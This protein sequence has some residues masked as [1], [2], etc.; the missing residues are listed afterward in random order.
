MSEN[1]DNR[2]VRMQFDNRQF[3]KGVQTTTTSLHKLKESLKLDKAAEGFNKISSAAKTVDLSVLMD[4]AE[5]IK[6]RFSAFGIIGM[7]VLQNITNMAISTGRRLVDALSFNSI[8]DGFAEYETQMGAI[9]TIMANVSDKGYG[10][11]DVTKNLDTLNTY[12]D[13]TIYNFT[14]MTRNIGTFTAA[15]VDLNEAT[16]AIQGIANLAAVSGSTSQQ[17]SVAMYQ[18]SQ[19]LA[20][21][22]VRLQDWNSV[23]NA[24]MGGEV[25]QKALIRTSEHLQ[26]GAKAAIAAKGSFRESL[27]TG[28]MTKEVLTE[29]L[30]MF[31]TAAETQE[32]YE[33][34]VKKFLDKGYSQEEATQMADMARTAGDAATKVKTFTQ[35]ID[36]LKEAL[37]SGWTKSWSYI[38][39]DFGEA[40]E[41]FTAIS[42]ELGSIIDQSSD[43]RN[44]LL[45]SWHDLGGRTSLL[46]G[47][48][49]IYTGIKN[50]I[51][52]MGSAFR[53]VIPPMTAEKLYSLTQA[54][55]NFTKKLIPG[56][57]TLNEF[58]SI[59]KGFISIFSILG[60]AIKVVITLFSQLF[61]IS[62]G[63]SWLWKNFRSLLAS[64]GDFISGVNDRFNVDEAVAG[65]QNWR[66]HVENILNQVKNYF[67]EFFNKLKS[68]WNNSGIPKNVFDGAIK[69]LQFI[70]DN[71]KRLIPAIAELLK[72]GFKTIIQVVGQ[73]FKELKNNIDL[74]DIFNFI[75]VGIFVKLASNFKSLSNKIKDFLDG[76]PFIGTGKDSGGVKDAVAAVNPVQDVVNSVKTLFN[77]LSEATNQLTKSIKIGQLVLIAGAILTIVIAMKKISELDN[78]QILKGLA[79]IATIAIG[80]NKAMSVLNKTLGGNSLKLSKFIGLSLFVLA[81]AEAVLILSKAIRKL[82]DLRVR[83][84]T[85]SLLA[86]VGLMEVLIKSTDRILKSTG[87]ARTVKIVGTLLAFSYAIKILTDSLKFISDIPFDKMSMSVLALEALMF[88]LAGCMKIMSNVKFT[89]RDSIG[90]LAIAG[91][92]KILSKVIKDLSE[93]DYDK[94]KQGFKLLTGIML[95]VIGAMKLMPKN[96][97]SI[98]NGFGS[99]LIG[100]ASLE[101]VHAIKTLSELDW[102]KAK[103]SMIGLSL[104]IGSVSLVLSLM[105]KLTSGHKTI[106]SA[107]AIDLVTLALIPLA[108]ALKQLSSK[109]ADSGKIVGALMVLM[110]A[111]SIMALILGILAHFNPG[112][113][114]LAAIALDLVTLALIPIANAIKDLSSIPFDNASSTLMLLLG[115]ITTLGLISTAMGLFGF[116]PL[117]GALALDFASLSLIPIAYALQKVSS[118]DINKAPQALSILERVIGFLAGWSVILGAFGPLT[119]LGGL[120]LMFISLSLIPIANGIERFSKIKFEDAIHGIEILVLALG[121]IAG[122]SVPLGLLAPLEILADIALAIIAGPLSGIADVLEKFSKIDDQNETGA[123]H[124]AAT[125]AALAVGLGANNLNILGA[126]TVAVVADHIGALA[127][128]VAKWKDVIPNPNLEMGLKSLANGLG[129]LNWDMLGAATVNIVQENVGKLA[130]SVKAWDDVIPNPNL[131]VGLKSLANGL[132]ALNWDILGA[133]TIAISSDN[134][135]TL[136]GSISKWES[137]KF[138][139]TL[140]SSLKTMAEG[141]NEFGWSDFVGTGVIALAIEPFSNLPEA[142]KKW[143][144]ASN[145]LQNIEIKDG[146]QKLAEGLSSF[147]WN[148][149]IAGG[150]MASSVEPLREMASSVAAWKDVS[151]PENIKTNLENLADGVGAFWNKGWGG[152]VLKDITPT[153]AQLS[154]SVR[155]WEGVTVPEGIEGQLESLANGVKKFDDMYTSAEELKM[156]GSAVGDFAW[157]MSTIGANDPTTI[158][159][160]ISTLID[161]I[162]AQPE[163]LVGVADAFNT[164]LQQIPPAIEGNQATI[165]AALVA[166]MGSASATV[167]NEG[168]QFG[169]AG[170][171][172]GQSLATSLATG[173]SNGQSEIT[174][175]INLL[176][177]GMKTTFTSEITV[178]NTE[179][180]DN[181]KNLIG[182]FASGIYANSYM[183]GDAAKSAVQQ[184]ASDA[185]SKREDFYNIGL[186]FSSGLANGIRANKSQVVNAA[187]EVAA[188]AAAASKARLAEKSPSK[189]TTEQGEYFSIGLANGIR[190]FKQTVVLAASDVAGGAINTLDSNMNRLDSRSYSPKIT[191]VISSDG[192]NLLANLSLNRSIKMNAEVNA[193]SKD[194]SMI[195]NS[196][197]ELREDLNKYTTALKDADTSININQTNLSPKALDPSEV[198]RNTKN[199]MSLARL[200]GR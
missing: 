181:G 91:T 58:H 29:T 8:R 128:G 189:I 196:I 47:I 70:Y 161:G 152:D 61:H 66:E 174:T 42:K 53:E 79:T 110:S 160:N 60:K 33:A 55:E 50:I 180:Y 25:F 18:L 191:P 31:A 51:L 1:I 145:V 162:A 111:L 112:G 140:G 22:T 114:I 40:K 142:F 185:D 134:L 158:I 129:A 28:W 11:A 192:A 34:A 127:E 100:L 3:E 193:V 139:E 43:A 45:Q 97:K 108:N 166:M 182:Q 41:M 176:V 156:I 74:N 71:M 37:G 109:D 146:M 172:V 64:I 93:L 171:T 131:E 136:A 75:G 190:N 130:S 24:G 13:K 7:T 89:M 113:Q 149:M 132:G 115:A 137:V 116:A 175:N 46:N 77:G 87:P 187:I 184:A 173:V 49:N 153:I 14:E 84:I 151:V 52:E 198:Y 177:S 68:Q 159:G 143:Q 69:A 121:A 15:G 101:F 81:F 169:A 56:E 5:T 168:G 9:Q 16:A 197:N 122:L 199:A 118:I 78:P 12:A 138:P 90:L 80:L 98:S 39:G 57:E 88:G 10:L 188:A 104:F 126:A 135:G 86:I 6:H 165:N 36:T 194:G 120:A 72:G 2:I 155:A 65:L 92:I 102:E 99:I 23:V 27:Q 144:D 35:L 103:K 148:E 200:G 73:A 163:K 186:N 59:F 67:K 195:V 54:F 117:I 106:G 30:D 170:L 48:A 105:S 107:V 63:G 178:A 76:L 96:G 95:D 123:K 124:L 179:F 83:D 82:S 183:A 26:T 141:L 62:K 20:S 32:E 133:T 154:Y 157:S 19:A 119:L 38:F 167:Q 150:A 4:A 147:G 44:T 85:K 94:A 164:A 125:L 21:G 17:A